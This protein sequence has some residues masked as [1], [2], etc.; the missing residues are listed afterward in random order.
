M[1]SNEIVITHMGKLGDFACCLPVASWLYKTKNKKIHFVFPNKFPLFRK[2]ES[3]LLKQE[4][5]ARVSY[6][7]FPVEHWNYGGQPYKF[8]PNEFDIQCDEYYNFGIRTSEPLLKYLSEFYA[9]EYSLDYDR[10][11]LLALDTW[12]QTEECI[13]PEKEILQFQP[14]AVLLDFDKDILH[15]LNRAKAAAGI[16]CWQSGFL[17]LLDLAGIIPIRIYRGPNQ[18]SPV[19]YLK[20][21]AKYTFI[22][23]DILWNR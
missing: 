17:S 16:F 3:L 14:E 7:D 12:K 11:F 6:A 1:Q 9:E 5:T 10:H 2:M 4:M 23:T 22:Q 18:M 19:L 20:N 15:N 8:D 13:C 21:M